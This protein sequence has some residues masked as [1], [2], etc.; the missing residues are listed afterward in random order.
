MI[1]G[2]HFVDIAH[3]GARPHRRT[4]LVDE[5]GKLSWLSTSMEPWASPGGQQ[6]GTSRLRLFGA[7]HQDPSQLTLRTW[8]FVSSA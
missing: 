3:A 7:C 5:A 4:L 2:L 6:S 1:M 8:H